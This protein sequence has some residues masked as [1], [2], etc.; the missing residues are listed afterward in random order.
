M[1]WQYAIGWLITLPFEI[2]AAG[3]TIGKSS[4]S[5]K[6]CGNQAQTPRAVLVVKRPSSDAAQIIGIIITLVFGSLSS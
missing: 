3:I 5:R 4:S 1:G 2:T 6:S